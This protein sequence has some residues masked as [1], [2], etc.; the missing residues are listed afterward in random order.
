MQCERC[1]QNKLFL[2]YNFFLQVIGVVWPGH[3]GHLQPMPLVLS[4]I[5]PICDD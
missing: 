4:R 3:P 2:S 5:R 1:K